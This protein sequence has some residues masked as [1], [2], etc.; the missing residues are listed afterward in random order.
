M[1]T[2]A[3]LRPLLAAT[4][5]TGVASTALVAQAP[6]GGQ[7]RIP[8]I[9]TEQIKCLPEAD[10]G[11]IHAEITPEVGGTMTRLYFRWAQDEDFYYV[12]MACAGKGRYWGVPPKPDPDNEM[13][14]YY[15]AVVDPDEQVLAKSDMLQAPVD[16]DCEIELTEQQRGAAEN[17]TVGETT[18]EQVGEE[19]DGFL[20]D[21][22]VTRINPLGILR[23]DEK[24]RAC[25][26]AWWERKG[27]MIPAAAG[28]VGTG[29]VI[30]HD[31]PR[32][33]SPATPL[34]EGGNG[35]GSSGGS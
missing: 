34:G 25:V 21:G 8:K 9:E 33:S 16:K 22:V 7:Y 29:I 13:V 17:M 19:V 23:G 2:H 11:V 28:L 6:R 32:E 26:I 20:C 10:N 4:L 31:S 14:E 5:L 3:I 30:S 24:C 18:F 1:T 15:T 27:I 35:D 12:P